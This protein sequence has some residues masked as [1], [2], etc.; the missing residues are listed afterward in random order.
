MKALGPHPAVAAGE[1]QQLAAAR[2]LQQSGRKDAAVMM[3]RLRL[4][5]RLRFKVCDW[6]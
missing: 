4:W 1:V 3:A 6:L 2:P 5:P